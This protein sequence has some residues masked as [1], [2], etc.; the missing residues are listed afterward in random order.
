MAFDSRKN[1]EKSS[2]R[3]AQK[4][5]SEKRR[6]YSNE[7]KKS[8]PDKEST[9]PTGYQQFEYRNHESRINPNEKTEQNNEYILNDHSAVSNSYSVRKS[10][11]P[12]SISD[13]EC[14]GL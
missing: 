1:A 3:R 13:S 14:S 11:Q 8:F 12:R 2:G 4:G 10:S 9:A 6:S 5:V 7:R